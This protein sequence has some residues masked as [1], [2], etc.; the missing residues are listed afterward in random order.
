VTEVPAFH[1]PPRDGLSWRRQRAAAM[2]R[3]HG[4]CEAGTEACTGRAE[5]VHHLAGRFS[6]DLSNLLAVCLACHGWIHSRPEQSYAR[7]WMRKRN[8]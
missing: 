1:K 3:A 6:H 2:A 8:R 5:H 7:G 4:A